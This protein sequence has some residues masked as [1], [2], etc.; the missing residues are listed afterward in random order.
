[1]YLD[2]RRPRRRSR[3]AAG[4]AVATVTTVGALGLLSACGQSS[5]SPSAAAG[6]ITP[7]PGQS[8]TAGTPGTAGPGDT[9]GST[10]GASGMPHMSMPKSSPSTGAPAAP[11]AGDAV[12][13]KNF[14]FSPATL[15][16]KAGTTVTWTNQDTDAHTV[17]SA[18]SGGP[19]HS[20]ALAT[21]AAYSYTFT[22]PGTYAYLC[23][24]H[25]FMTATV[26]V[27]R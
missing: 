24:I 19:L 21:H 26:E 12:A 7:G 6:A 14:A 11:V 4:L 23:T 2:F 9:A 27:T 3:V 25:P 15:K 16:V 1:M 18:G 22:K 5:H 20:A 10:P 17:T 8:R 13:I